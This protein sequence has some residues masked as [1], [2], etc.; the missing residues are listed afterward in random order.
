MKKS[1]LALA[2]LGAFAGS[3]FA[4]ASSVTIFGKIDQGIGKYAGSRD[5]G[6]LD[7][8]TGTNGQIAG[9]NRAAGAQPVG[10]SRIA[11]RGY[12]DLGAGLGAVFAFE[13]RFQPDLGAAGDTAK[14][15][16]GFSFV[17]LRSASLGTLTIGRH[18]NSAF[19]S[20]QAVIDPFEGE[21]VAS[22]RNTGMLLGAFSD[23]TRPTPTAFVEGLVGAPGST[24]VTSLRDGY[25][26]VGAIG[27][28]RVDNSLK[29]DISMSGVGFSASVGESN[30][31]ATIAETKR[32][33][34]LALTYTGGPLFV[35]L[36]YENPGDAD[37]KLINVG[38]R[39]KMGTVTLRGAYSQGTTSG[40]SL[41]TTGLGT[42]TALATYYGQSR[43]AK[44][45]LIGANMAIGAGDLKIG[46]ATAKLDAK[47]PLPSLDLAKKASI[48]YHHALSKRTKLYADFTRDS[49]VTAEKTGYDFGI[50][51]AF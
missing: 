31:A 45:Y 3:A 26:S 20:V 44:G 23:T 27:R 14:F 43:D 4:Q 22:L 41:Q 18:Y 10:G 40:T 7:G 46:Y 9:A 34:A 42:S 11:F 29:Y 2:V 5:K 25:A 19:Q 6:V 30:P 1:L 13:H 33:Y 38:A 47:G 49:A 8:A 17:G 21:T 28:V 15:W 37:D 39:F 16:N 35:G 48:G 32:P 36:G 24:A 12:E 51:H 50:Q